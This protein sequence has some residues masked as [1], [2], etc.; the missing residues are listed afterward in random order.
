MLCDD[1]DHVWHSLLSMGNQMTVIHKQ[2]EIDG[3]CPSTAVVACCQYG[4]CIA[5]V[6]PIRLVPESAV[7]ENVVE[8]VI[9]VGQG[10]D[11]NLPG[12]SE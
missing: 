12:W 1:D 8:C 9:S 5:T 10:T 7:I 4:W 6:G 11:W 2:S 3:V